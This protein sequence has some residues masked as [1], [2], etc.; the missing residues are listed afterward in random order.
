MI[1]LYTFLVPIQCTANSGCFLR[2]KRAA[3]VRR[4][5]VVLGFSCVQC[6][7]VS[8]PNSDMDYKIFN[9]RAFLC[10]RI[11][12]GVRHTDNESAQQFD[13]EKLSQC[14]FLCSGRDSNLWPWN[15]LDLEADALPIE[16]PQ[17]KTMQLIVLWRNSSGTN[18]NLQAYYLT[19]T[20][21]KIQKERKNNTTECFFL[22]FN[23]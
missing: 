16:P 3:M 8:C 1:R 4:Y 12:T 20:K 2:G 18:K 14:V 23:I 19:V 5:P 10:V 15:P 7:R 6:F 13:S 17:Q 21:K 22:L 9:V 11:H